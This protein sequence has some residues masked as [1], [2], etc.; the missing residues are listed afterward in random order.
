MLPN[1]CLVRGVILRRTYSF[2]IRRIDSATP[3]RTVLCPDCRPFVRTGQFD[4]PLL[5]FDC[6][7]GAGACQ[8][9]W[10]ERHDGDPPGRVGWFHRS[11]CAATQFSTVV[12]TDNPS[13]FPV[14]IRKPWL[15][16]VTKAA[17][18]VLPPV[19]SNPRLRFSLLQTT[20]VAHHQGENR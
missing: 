9:T 6:L 13:R 20:P 4:S 10:A 12:E 17:I 16:H 2:A 11:R 18:R 7:V 3:C 5:R 15:R 1:S 19:I 8:E 14:Q